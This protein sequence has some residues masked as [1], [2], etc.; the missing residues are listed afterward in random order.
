MTPTVGSAMKMLG[1]DRDFAAIDPVDEGVTFSAA[2]VPAWQVIEVDHSARTVRIPAGVE[3]DLG[4]TAK[5]LCAES[6]GP[7]RLRPC[8]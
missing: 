5:A 3:L 6:G 2:P 4:A 8:G 7:G 1:Y